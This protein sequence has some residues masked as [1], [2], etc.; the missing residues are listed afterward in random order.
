ML[1]G[2]RPRKKRGPG[3]RGGFA[4]LVALSL[5]SFLLVTMIAFTSVVRVESQAAM[6][7]RDRAVAREHARLSMFIALGELQEKAGPD[8]AVTAE[9]EIRGLQQIDSGK[10]HVTGVWDT[11]ELR[12]NPAA[13][14]SWLVSYPDDE[15]EGFSIRQPY[16]PDDSVELVGAGTL[17]PAVD[18]SDLV[19]A[20]T[21]AIP[22][23]DE[24]EVGRMAWW[25]GDEG[26]KASL[27]KGNRLPALRND[28][29]FTADEAS[30]LA[31]TT[32]GRPRVEWLFA[33]YNPA[34]TESTTEDTWTAN[35]ADLARM[36]HAGQA[37]YL[38]D[39]TGEE[40]LA[41]YYDA[42]LMHYGVLANT[43]EGGL[44]LDLT[45]PGT[46]D[47]QGPF[48]LNTE[49]RSFLDQ[50][51]D[52]NDRA[53]ARGVPAG[54]LREGQPA[55]PVGLVLTEM[56][57]YC[58]FYRESARSNTLKM[59][60]RLRADVW[61]PYAFPLG[62]SPR[63]VDDFILQIEGIPALQVEWETGN[64]SRQ[65]S[66]TVNPTALTWRDLE[67][68]RNFSWNDFRYDIYDAMEVGEVRNIRQK[69]QAVL[70]QPGQALT[71][72][73][74]P[75]QVTDDFFRIRAPAAELTLRV[76]TLD[77][78]VIQ[79]FSKIPFDALDTEPFP[80]INI[81][82]NSD[83]GYS[84]FQFA[85]HFR[86]FDEVQRLAGGSSDLER[87]LSEVDPRS[88]LFALADGSVESDLFDIS[89]DPGYAAI[90][91]TLFLGRPEFFYGGGRIGENQG[92]NNYHRFYDYTATDPVS[93]GW[94]QNL[95]VHRRRPYSI[96]NPWGAD[97]NRVF[98]RYFFSTVPRAAEPSDWGPGQLLDPDRPSLGYRPLANVHLEP[99]EGPGAPL[100]VDGL[101]AATAGKNLL[102]AG[103]FNLHSVRPEAW[104]AV[105][106]GTNLR[107]WSFRR[108][109]RSDPVARPTVQNG[110]FRYPMG[111]DRHYEH[112][113]ATRGRDA[114][115]NHT[116]SY[117][118]YPEITQ[119]EKGEW[120]KNKWQP[121]WAAAYT[122]GMRELREGRNPDQINDVDD[123]ARAI[124]R[125]IQERGRP[126]RG[127]EELVN[128]GLL[129]QAIDDTKINTVVNRTYAEIGYDYYTQVP[130]YAPSFLTQADVLSTLAPVVQARSDTFTIRA[131]G[132]RIN[133]VTGEAEG[134]AW[135]E[136]VVQ[137]LPEPVELRPGGNAEADYRNPPG[138][139]GRR[140]VVRDF[141]W[142]EEGEI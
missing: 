61:N 141:R 52:A 45:H 7:A 40:V 132:N 60:I 10:R 64:G 79:E 53:P 109:E 51:P 95:Y 38:A 89:E 18:G 44:K 12:G 125:R 91:G 98:D 76:L 75:S 15:V 16:G 139:F 114:A 117:P 116:R 96:G 68:N 136:A 17:G 55:N 118:E 124:V 77:G 108:Y 42:T 99:V 43:A 86:F 20:N 142:L 13:E 80:A 36:T 94:L 105:L 121:D 19:R 93:V 126:F 84:D 72:D 56:A 54:S 34:T 63:R 134:Q 39:V 6:K 21:V 46:T 74:R 62:F 47:P 33:A 104:K 140:F 66:F 11:L 31:Q 138:R 111:A 127:L 70:T 57:L 67:T 22:G 65:G 101:R 37:G 71:G 128:S 35:E 73:D 9:A 88:A 133:A 49:L 81:R 87:W 119:V 103:A 130:R 29:A 32:P 112:P 14:P 82:A 28:P 48:E 90:D 24:L 131:W 8:T 110:F 2:M 59:A 3:R 26:G 58:G 120:Y 69:I 25:V 23:A 85:Y 27:G 1:G 123:L 122:V 107:D 5:M 115:G 137:R 83:P 100:S 102:V 30:R 113:F 129:Q 135:C 78:H 50:R 4:L 97:L 41:R 92:G 106:G